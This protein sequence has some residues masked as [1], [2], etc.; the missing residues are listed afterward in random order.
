MISIKHAS[1]VSG[2]AATIALVNRASIDTVLS[3]GTIRSATPDTVS[4]TH[5][6][7]RTYELQP[8]QALVVSGIG[9]VAISSEARQ[10]SGE[11]IKVA[12]LDGGNLTGPSSLW[13]GDCITYTLSPGVALVVTRHTQDEALR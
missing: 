2:Q 4:D 8:A 3:E 9:E 5:S 7:E 6:I 13:P 10:G 11:F 12:R 1:G